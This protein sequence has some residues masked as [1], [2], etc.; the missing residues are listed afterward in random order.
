MACSGVKMLDLSLISLAQ[1]YSSTLHGTE[2][3]KYGHL[4]RIIDWEQRASDNSQ[5]ETVNKV[6]VLHSDKVSVQKLHY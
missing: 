6:S 3:A 4:V 1:F 2:E 5:C